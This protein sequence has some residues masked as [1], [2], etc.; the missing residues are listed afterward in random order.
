[1]I[2]LA[3]SR[4]NENNF[5][6]FLQA[7]ILIIITALKFTSTKTVGGLES[8]IGEDNTLLLIISTGWSIKTLAMG[9]LQSVSMSKEDAVP[10]LGKLLL[11]FFV[12]ISCLSRLLGI[13]VFFAPCLGLMDVLLHW[14]MGKLVPS[15]SSSDRIFDVGPSETFISFQEVW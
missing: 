6:Q 9:Y 2:F 12:L 10:I 11:F 15:S 14:K 1:M 8:L 7:L 4:M 13:L 3:K 5:E